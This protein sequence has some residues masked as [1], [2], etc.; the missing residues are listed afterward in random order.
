MS[1]EAE[2]K[3]GKTVADAAKAAGVSHLIF[4]SLIHVTKA[5]KGALPNVSHFD[6]KAEVEEYIRA[7]GVPAS[8]VMPGYFM[9]NLISSLQKQEDGSYQMFLPISDAAKFPL[10]DVATDTGISFPI[11]IATPLLRRTV[12]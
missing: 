2:I 3:Q 6:G 1:H 11:S 8:F 9:S 7:S 10:F 4:S 5:T 12:I